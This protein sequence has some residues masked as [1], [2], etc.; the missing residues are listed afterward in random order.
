MFTLLIRFFT[1][2]TLFCRNT[3]PDR[4]SDNRNWTA[5]CDVRFVAVLVCLPPAGVQR[6]LEVAIDTVVGVDQAGYRPLHWLLFGKALV[7][8]TGH[9]STGRVRPSGLK[10]ASLL[11]GE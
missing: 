7:V 2:L 5:K 1:V 11:N 6:Q 4:K 10:I 8:G 9:V 3:C